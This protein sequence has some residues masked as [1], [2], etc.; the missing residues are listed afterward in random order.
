MTHASKLA[1]EDRDLVRR[2]EDAGQGHV[3]RFLPNLQQAEAEAL[4]ADA[5]GV[6]LALLARLAAEREQAPTGTVTPPGD[7]LEPLEDSDD[8]RRLRNAAHDR[9]VHELSER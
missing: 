6:D 5:R 1:A 4:V 7:E 9:G 2:F 3:F 8:Y